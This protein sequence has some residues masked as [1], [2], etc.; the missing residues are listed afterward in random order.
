MVFVALGLAVGCTTRS[1]EQLREIAEIE[2]RVEQN[3]ASI[4]VDDGNGTP[5]DVAVINNYLELADWLVDHH[6]DVNAH[7]N[8]GETALH[9]AVIYDRAPNHKMIRF[10]LRNGANVNATRNYGETP[11]HA[12]AFLGLKE[13]AGILLEHGAEANTRAGRGET[14]LHLASS[15]TGYPELVELLLR[16]GA[17]IEARQNNGATALHQAAL[18]GNVKVVELL[19]KKG[20]NPA[21]T[22]QVGDTP[23]H[24]AAVFGQAQVAELLLAHR[25]GINAL[26]SEGHTPLWQALHAPAIKSS[27]TT[28]GPVDTTSVV[29]VLRRH[30]GTE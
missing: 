20:A 18:I 29:D 23:L 3:P 8:Q 9:R 1:K 27:A 19:L 24:Y 13:V 14:P 25:A 2:R 7:D 30:G 6:A 4:N 15:P 28:S 5:L 11:L 16:H 21:A 17:D 22:N 26:N 12:A 10:L